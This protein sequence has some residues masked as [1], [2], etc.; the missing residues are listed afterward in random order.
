MFTDIVTRF[1]PAPAEDLVIEH[2]NWHTGGDLTEFVT[3]T[4]TQAA[5][6]G[7]GNEALAA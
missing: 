2:L 5:G 3:W 4:Y 1:V 7:A 6:P